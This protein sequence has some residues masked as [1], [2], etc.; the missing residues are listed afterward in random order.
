MVTS[1]ALHFVV[2]YS[3]LMGSNIVVIA[4]KIVISKLSFFMA[5][6]VHL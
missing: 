5:V 3:T 1:V 6:R 2:V 4:S